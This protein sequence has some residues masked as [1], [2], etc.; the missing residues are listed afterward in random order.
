MRAPYQT[1]TFLYKKVEN[2]FQFLILKRSDLNFWQGIAGGGEE[3]ETP[4]ET[5]KRET[6]EEVGLQDTNKFFQLSTISSIPRKNISGLR[7]REDLKGIFNIVP[8]FCFACEVPINFEPTISHEHTNYTWLDFK[9]AIQKVNFDSNK[10]ALWELNN[11][12]TSE[13]YLEKSEK[14]LGNIT[15]NNAKFI[16]NLYFI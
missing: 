4:F 1:L 6:K 2:N 13:E 9:E 3:G 8:E 16:K 5:A 12:L 10:T 11:F 7:N 15:K 14:D